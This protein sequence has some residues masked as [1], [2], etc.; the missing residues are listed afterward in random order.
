MPERGDG[1]VRRDRLR[2]IEVA[3]RPFGTGSPVVLVHGLAQDHRI[4]RQVQ[5]DFADHF[6]VAYDVR[7][8]GDTSL[9][10]AD[11]TLAQ[12]AGDLVALLE[13]TGS[14][15][16]VGF[17]L[18]GAIALWAATERPDLVA[19]V[20]AVATSSVVGSAATA[21]LCEHI[22]TVKSGDPASIRELMRTDTRSQLGEAAIDPGPIAKER[23]SAI[24]NPVGY[25]NAAKAV[26]SM[27]DVSLHDR[28]PRISAPVLIVS[29]EHDTW[30]PRRAAELLLERLPQASYIELAGVGHLVTDTDPH[31]LA[32][33]VRRWIESQEDL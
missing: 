15:T 20:V 7:G 33:T 22:A 12:L 32:S 9:G 13:R 30:C 17:S 28:L 31:A 29:G 14:A 5:A 19:R 10:Q 8:H 11:G 16:C 1:E 6:T 27:R 2:D 21:A 23:V 18:G 25:I 4:W 3:W 26:L 24:R